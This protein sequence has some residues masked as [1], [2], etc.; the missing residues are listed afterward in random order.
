ML[1][2]GTSTNYT[3]KIVLL[4]EGKV[5]KT[6]IIMRFVH[7]QFNKQHQQTIQAAF[8]NKKINFEYD[9]NRQVRC[10]L[11]ICDTAGQEIFH[12]LGPI[13]YRGS[14]GAI[15]VYDISN[16][17]S[18]EKIKMWIKELK[19]VVGDDIACV[20][21]GNK[22]D[23]VKDG[24]IQYDISPH[25]EYAKSQNALHF[26]TSAKHNENIDELFLEISKQMIKAHDEKQTANATLNR[27]NSMRRRLRVEDENTQNDESGVNTQSGNSSRCCGI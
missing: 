16:Q 22:I 13:Y 4:G 10:S 7:D 11:N 14:N 23:L 9:D 25:L 6:S 12:S 3:F 8:L 19:K 20:I 15:L 21:V 27:S 1:S 17:D 26:L 18:F 2:D 24:K 5:G